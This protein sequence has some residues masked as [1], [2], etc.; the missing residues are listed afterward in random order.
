MLVLAAAAFAEPLPLETA[1]APGVPTPPGELPS[2][3]V[4]GDPV[5]K[6]K[7]DDAVGVVF[8]GSYVGCTGTLI[9]PRVVLTAGHCMPSNTG[10]QVSDVLIGSKNWYQDLYGDMDDGAELVAVEEWVEY[11]SSQA[12]YDV[13]LL[14]LDRD[15]KKADPRPIALECILDHLENGAKAQ[16]VGFGVTSETGG[17]Y[18]VL[19][20]EAETEVVDKSCKENVIDGIYTGCHDNVRPGGELAAGGNGTDACYGDSGGPL[21]L[22][23]PDGDFVVGVTSRAFLG[24][25]WQYPCRDGGIWVRPDAIIDW[26]EEEAGKRD[27]AYPTCNL[28]PEPQVPEIVT[29]KNEAAVVAVVPG[30]PDGDAGDAL[31]EIVEAPRHGTATVSGLEVTYTPD[32]GFVGSDAL[33]VAVTD[34]GTDHDRT[35]APVTVELTVPVTVTRRG[36][37]GC[38]NADPA[39]LVGVLGAVAL[40]RSRRRGW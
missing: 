10:Y 37:L 9:G 24:V 32:G 16:I 34:G 21:Y 6:A 13:G 28:P 31:V 15:A 19:L 40:I 18:N 8:M 12:T 23:T 27:L 22:K 14:F 36:F 33:T 2:P 25:D 26:I 17:G 1:G 29:R 3:V 7:W 11:P 38:S 30:D 35:G 39:G 4:G 5:G 20:N